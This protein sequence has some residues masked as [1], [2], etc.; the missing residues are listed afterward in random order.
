MTI[1]RRECSKCGIRRLPSSFVSAR[2]RVCFNC[3]KATAKT[4]ARRNHVKKN[5]ELTP[6]EYHRLQVAAD[7]HCMGCGKERKYNL[8]VDHD[9]VV[10]REYGVR[11]SIRALLCAGCNGV[12]RKAGD[13]AATL[14]E[15]ADILDCWPTLALI[16]GVAG[17]TVR[18]SK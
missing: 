13:N 14:R 9:H 16:G 4:A 17:S 7:G 2:G 1:T 3:R 18:S 10:E 15:L 6:E 5:Y 11:F 12:L 8:H